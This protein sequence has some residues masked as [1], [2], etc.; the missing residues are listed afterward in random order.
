MRVAG[1]LCLQADH[2]APSSMRLL[3]LFVH[4][5]TIPC[6]AVLGVAS[7]WP[8]C[9][10]TVHACMQAGCERTEKFDEEGIIVKALEAPYHLGKPPAGEMSWIKWKRDYGDSWEV[11]CL[12]VGGMYAHEGRSAGLAKFICALQAAG[13]QRKQFC[14]F[15]RVYTG[16]AVRHETL[17]PPRSVCFDC[18]VVCH[19]CAP[20]FRT[21]LFRVV[22]V[23]HV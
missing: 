23:R 21:C 22:F 17:Q 7:L 14:T 16:L 11:D 1:L 10:R 15:A 2:L 9:A 8:L 18:V 5:S 12:I 6:S 3:T 13:V 19:A 20:G 4:L